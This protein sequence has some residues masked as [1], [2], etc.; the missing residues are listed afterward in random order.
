MRVTGGANTTSTSARDMGGAREACTTRA[1]ERR[2]MGRVAAAR[3]LHV[4][5]QDEAAARRCGKKGGSGRD[6][7]MCFFLINSRVEPSSGVK[8][9]A[10]RRWACRSVVQFMFASDL[11]CVALPLFIRR[12]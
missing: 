9:Q 7:D 1:N 2:W 12:V 10:T 3:G 4:H 11:R 6:K 8:A 5:V